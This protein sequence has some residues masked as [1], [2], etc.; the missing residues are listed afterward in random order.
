MV[1][2]AGPGEARGEAVPP[3]ALHHE[4]RQQALHVAAGRVQRIDRGT[5]DVPPL[6]L[7]AAKGPY[8]HIMVIMQNGASPLLLQSASYDVGSLHITAPTL[9]RRNRHLLAF[10]HAATSA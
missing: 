1:V 5:D 10:T 3:E 9:T 8:G 2:D 4:Q 6:G 7:H